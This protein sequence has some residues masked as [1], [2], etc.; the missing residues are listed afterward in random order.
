[1][2][3]GVI[4]DIHSNA[5][6]LKAVFRRLK[7]FDIELVLCAGDLVGYYPMPNETIELLRQ[8]EWE[9]Q[10][11]RGNHDA[12]VLNETPSDFSIDAKRAI[13][14]TRRELTDENWED[15]SRLPIE[16]RIEVNNKEIYVAHGSPEN[17]ISE[18]IWEED[19]SEQ[20]LNYW[21]PKDPPELVILGHTHRQYDRKVGGTHF[22][23]PGSVG[24]PRDGDPKAG[25]AVV[26]TDAMSVNRY[27]VDYNIDDIAEA[28]KKQLPRSLADRLYQGK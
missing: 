5:V 9:V 2:N 3:V 27:R 22:L 12:A 25:F 11:I 21:F 15:L 17:P 6:A 8:S 4:S 23:N 20:A 10:S 24:Q 14:W 19:L 1:M 28:T 18:Y 13:D 7:D 26:D 16:H